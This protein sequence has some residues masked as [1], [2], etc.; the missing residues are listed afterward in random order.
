MQRGDLVRVQKGRKVVAYGVLL[1][2]R[3][4]T[5]DP[6]KNGVCVTN[7]ALINDEDGVRKWYNTRY[8]FLDN[9]P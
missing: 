4:V 1:K 8:V 7:Q 6:P 5:Y 3:I 9:R 2:T